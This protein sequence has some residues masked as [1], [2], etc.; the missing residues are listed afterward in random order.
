MSVFRLRIMI[1]RV[2]IVE[3]YLWSFCL[4]APG[5]WAGAFG[6]LSAVAVKLK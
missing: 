3:V 2:K 1:L 6:F 4:V 5:V